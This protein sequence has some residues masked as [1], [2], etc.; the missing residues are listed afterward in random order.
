MKLFY[1][2]ITFFLIFLLSACAE[3]KIEKVESSKIKKYY[4]SKGFALIYNEDLIKTGILKKRLKEDDIYIMHSILKRNT[5][6]KI[7]NPENLIEINTKVFKK[8]KYPKLFN[9]VISRKTAKILKLDINNPYV[10]I[11]EIKKNKTFVAK[12]SNT[13]DEEKRVAE[14]APVEEIKIDNLSETTNTE[15][16]KP[17]KKYNFVIFISD[18]YYI[19]SANNL[20]N[21]LS[22]QTQIDTLVVKKINNNK[23]RLLAGPFKNFDSL[24]STY[25]SLN[26]QGFDELNIYRE[27]K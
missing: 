24:K 27:I 10:E 2:N 5:P 11:L 20:K 12:E 22:K 25:I 17:I 23:Y 18:F 1:K 6:V 16:K 19:N 15:Q 26:N 8:T 4:T 14:T 7:I 9:V 21:E 13:F 3:Y